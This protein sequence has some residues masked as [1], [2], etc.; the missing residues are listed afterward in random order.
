MYIYIVYFMLH[1]KYF[2]PLQHSSS[3]LLLVSFQNTLF[4]HLKNILDC[5]KLHHNI[6]LSLSHFNVLVRYLM[7]IPRWLSG[8]ESVNQKMQVQSLGQADPLEK[9]MASHSSILACEII[10]TEKT[11]GLYSLWGCKR[12]GPSC[13]ATKQQQQQCPPLCSFSG[14]FL[15]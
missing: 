4:Q 11:V 2:T 14:D 9:E 1:L 7:E 10:C 3:K 5:Q 8:K 6:Q 15:S 13:L 12:V